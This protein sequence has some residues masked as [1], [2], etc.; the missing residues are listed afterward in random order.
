MEFTQCA[1]GNYSVCKAGRPVGIP[2]ELLAF[3]M[4]AL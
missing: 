2:L 1:K 4:A 3:E